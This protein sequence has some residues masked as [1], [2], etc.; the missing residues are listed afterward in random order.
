MIWIGFIWAIKY[1]IARCWIPGSDHVL[2][3][4]GITYRRIIVPI[5]VGLPRFLVA[6]GRKTGTIHRS[7]R[8]SKQGS[9]VFPC[10]NFLGILI[11][12]LFGVCLFGLFGNSAYRTL[13]SRGFPG[14]RSNFGFSPRLG[15]RFD[16]GLKDD[17]RVSV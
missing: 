6:K 3:H 12:F 7:G 16:R 8:C 5:G 14:R 15:Q 11:L 10:W 1:E 9:F 2:D 17:F 13:V 4:A